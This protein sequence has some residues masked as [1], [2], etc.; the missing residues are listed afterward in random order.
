MERTFIRRSNMATNERSLNHTSLQYLY[1]CAN[2]SI[3]DRWWSLVC[4]KFGYLFERGCGYFVRNFGSLISLFSPS[5]LS[6]VRVPIVYRS[7]NIIFVLT[8]A[9]GLSHSLVLWWRFR[10]LIYQV[11]WRQTASVYWTLGVCFVLSYS[12]FELP[13]SITYILCTTV[14][15]MQL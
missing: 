8:R 14:F 15:D 7:H 9:R 10:L 4:L 6:F 2:T 1:G 12:L 3:S 13:H 5:G 11:V